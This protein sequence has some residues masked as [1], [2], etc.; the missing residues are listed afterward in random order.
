MRS[1]FAPGQAISSGDS[2]TGS[3]G[4]VTFTDAQAAVYGGSN[5]LYFAGQGDAADLYATADDWD[6]V[7]GDDG[8]V[9]LNGAQASVFGGGDH[10]YFAQGVANAASL[11]QTN[12]NDDFVVGGNGAVTLTDTQASIDGGGD[13]LCLAGASTA[14]MMGTNDTFVFQPAIGE[15]TIGGFVAS[16]VVQFSSA[17]FANWQALSGHIAQSGADVVISYDS[18]DKV[19]LTNASASSLTSANFKFA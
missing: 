1:S 19:T 13:V 12:G 2:V 15:A 9:T 11:Y 7:T 8:G 14:A 6:T 16:D 3:N 17:D 10:I 4:S 18:N 5:V